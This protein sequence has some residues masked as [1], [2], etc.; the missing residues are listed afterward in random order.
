MAAHIR[1]SL[2]APYMISYVSPDSN[3][4]DRSRIRVFETRRIFFGCVT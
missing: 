4:K 1:L 3:A 2:W